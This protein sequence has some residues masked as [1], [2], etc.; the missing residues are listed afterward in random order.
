M[1]SVSSVSR[2][3]E[4]LNLWQNAY[5][6]HVHRCYTCH[7]HVFFLVPELPTNTE[8]MSFCKREFIL[9]SNQG[10]TMFRD[11]SYFKTWEALSKNKLTSKGITCRYNR[12]LSERLYKFQYEQ[13]SSPPPSVICQTTGPKPLA[14][15]FLHIVR[16]RASSFNSQYPL[17]SLRSSSNFLRLLPCLLVTTICPFIFPSIT[18]FRRQFLCKMLPIQLAFRFIIS[19]RIF[20]CSLTLSNT[21]SS[22]EEKPCLLYW[23]F[24]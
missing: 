17:L 9:E 15:L 19:Y 18:C 3:K 16:S 12:K 23:W 7:C 6:S 20:L 8:N 1:T 22:L 2:T 14:K 5:L 24:C 10:M 11:I 4:R 21:S 13:S